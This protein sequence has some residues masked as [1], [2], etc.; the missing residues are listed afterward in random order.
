MYTFFKLCEQIDSNQRSKR[1]IHYI[2]EVQ[3]VETWIQSYCI[4]S[5]FFLSNKKFHVT[6]QF[7][8]NFVK[9]SCK[10]LHFASLFHLKF[11][12]TIKNYL[13]SEKYVESI[14][15]ILYLNQL[16]YVA[17]KRCTFPVFCKKNL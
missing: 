10:K 2:S 6:F 12:T 9:E 15:L 16:V 11:I 8:M 7:R 3:N 5:P 1:S 14:V 4:I 13:K 17:Q